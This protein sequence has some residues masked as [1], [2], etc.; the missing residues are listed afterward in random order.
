MLLNK[1]V[2]KYGTKKS[3]YAV[4]ASAAIIILA[5]LIVFA[6]INI[7]PSNIKNLDIT[8]NKTYTLTDQSKNIIKAVDAQV[9]VYKLAFRTKT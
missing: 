9:T 1:I 2:G 5:A 6:A 4:I 3:P 7:V 8:E